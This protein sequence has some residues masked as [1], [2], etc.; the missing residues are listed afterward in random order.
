M[1]VDQ[2]FPLLTTDGST[3]SGSST[4]T[5]GDQGP[6]VA[7]AL[8]DVLGWRP[9][10]RDTKAFNAALTAAFELNTVEGHVE[11]RHVQRGVAVQAD[12]GGIT[13]GQAS[14]YA[15]AKSSHEQITRMLDSLKPLRPDADPEDCEAFRA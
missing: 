11:A 5:G 10:S 7:A 2:A 6:T 1:D 12:L 3:R 15:R 9:R 14:L 4:A 8:R 13:G